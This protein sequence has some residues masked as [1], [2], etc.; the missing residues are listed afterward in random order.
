MDILGPFPPSN[1]RKFFLIATYYFTNLVEVVSLANIGE[2]NVKKLMWENIV[3]RFGIPL[4]I[5]ANNGL[6]FK[7]KKVVEFNEN[8]GI[9]QNFANV[10]YPETNGQAEASNK[11]I[12]ERLKKG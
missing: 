10:A 1:L 6:Q 7:S 4:M 8:L 11:V 5:V 2:T 3:T 12:L 9:R